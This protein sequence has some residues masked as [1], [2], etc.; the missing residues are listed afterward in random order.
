MENSNTKDKKF[1]SFINERRNIS[2]PN[3]ENDLIFQYSKRNNSIS[4]IKEPSEEIIRN[5]HN[6]KTFLAIPT[7]YEVRHDLFKVAFP[8]VGS[9]TKSEEENEENIGNSSTYPLLLLSI[10]FDS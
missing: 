9:A 10:K 6:F 7:G 8:E 3:D 4:N 2:D 5:K 1:H